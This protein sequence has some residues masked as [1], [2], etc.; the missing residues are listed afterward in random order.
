MVLTLLLAAHIAQAGS[1]LH[2]DGVNDHVTMGEASSLG[3]AEL[4]VECWFRWD[5]PGD[6]TAS[7]GSGGVSFYPLVAKG[8]GENDG[9]T[10]DMNWGLGVHGDSGTLAADFEDMADGSNHPVLGHTDVRDGAWHHAAVTYDGNVW[11]LYLDGVLDGEDDTAGATPRHDS[12]QH[13]GVATAMNSG[14]TPSGYF[15][16]AIDEVRVWSRA[17]SQDEIQDTINQAL[18][19]GTELVAR[20]G[21]DEGDGATAGDSVGGVDGSVVGASWTAQAPFD[22]NL[23]P[24]EPGLVHPDD[25]AEGLGRPVQLTIETDDAEGEPLQVR[26]YGR[27][28][29]T[30]LE[31]FTLVVLPDTQYYCAGR[32]EGE[33]A[34]FYAQTG[35]IVEQRQALNIAWVAHVGDLVDSADDDPDQWPVADE[36]MSLLEDPATTGLADGIPYGIAPGNHDQSP[37]GDPD[38]TTEYF[39]AYFGA[40]RFEGRAYYGG[41]HGENN[42]DHW[43]AF[44]ASGHAFLVIDLE[45]DQGGEDQGVLAWADQLIADHPDHRVIINAHHLLEDNG[46]LSDQGLVVYGALGHHDNLLLM[47]SGHLT[48]EAWRSDPAGT[49]GTVYTVMADYQ[50]DGGGGNGWLRIM[51]F[52][53][54]DALI[55]ISTHSPWLDEW[56]TGSDS[57]FELSWTPDDAGWELV[58]NATPDEDGVATAPW[59]GLEADTR[60]QW[61][62]EADDGAS[63]VTSDTWSFTTGD[64]PADTGQPLD[65]GDT[66][67][68]PPGVRHPDGEDCGCTSGRGR[69]GWLGMLLAAFGLA[70][71][72]RAGPLAHPHPRA[73]VHGA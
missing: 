64:Q 49:T 22:I 8:R 30:D 40:D 31:D 68:G 51:T 39:N 14:G 7:S 20:W 43:G 42:D 23:P 53:P 71:R 4:T 62:A 37:N 47:L 57:E 11:A 32:Y 5:G 34:M 21:F 2:F 1:A 27:E 16:G 48:A 59:R 35:W 63:S 58:G 73:S 13:M 10:V 36:A 70:R 12:I 52:S 17:R 6:A 50:F 25:D 3:L 26:F 29:P 56:A 18:T 44:E 41:H 9:S 15:R 60:Y 61:F 69:V 33:P 19:T 38:G 65:T 54:A 28:A 67:D 24:D 66:G 46:E 45:F 72:R 55:R